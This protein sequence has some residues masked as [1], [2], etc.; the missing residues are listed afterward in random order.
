MA[1]DQRNVEAI[2]P[3]EVD[4]AKWYTDICLKAQLGHCVGGPGHRIE[5]AEEE[6]PLSLTGHKVRNVDL[7]RDPS[8]G[9]GHLP[10]VGELAAPGIGRHVDD[11]ITHVSP[12]KNKNAPPHIGAKRRF[13]VPP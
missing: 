11:V 3:M 6:G 10:E 7:R 8:E 9:I 5:K 1:K 4:F 12:P 2:T 13:T